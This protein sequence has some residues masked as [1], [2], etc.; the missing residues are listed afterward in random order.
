MCKARERMELNR[1]RVCGSQ[2]RTKARERREV[3]IERV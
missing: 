2:T 1:E 3:N